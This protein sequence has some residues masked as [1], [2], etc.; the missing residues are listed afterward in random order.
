MGHADNNHAFVFHPAFNN[1]AAASIQAQCHNFNN[2]LVYTPSPQVDAQG[3]PL[4]VGPPAAAAALQSSMSGRS[5]GSSSGAGHTV[6]SSSSTNNRHSTQN[7]TTRGNSY[8]GMTASQCSMTL[9][10]R[11]SPGMLPD[12]TKTPPATTAE[13]YVYEPE[14]LEPLDFTHHLKKAT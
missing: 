6:S 2:L 7:S 4:A 10:E 3:R 14:L 13:A 5:A 1:T 11:I 8:E 12:T 9:W